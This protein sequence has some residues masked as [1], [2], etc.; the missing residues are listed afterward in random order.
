MK[1]Q[2]VQGESKT[3]KDEGVAWVPTSVPLLSMCRDMQGRIHTLDREFQKVKSLVKGTTEQHEGY[4]HLLELGMESLEIG[5]FVADQAGNIQMVNIVAERTMGIPR[6]DMIHRNLG[7]VWKEIGFPCPPF[8]RFRHQGRVFQ[9]REFPLDHSARWAHGTVRLLQDLTSADHQNGYHERQDRLAAM[10][11]MVGR[12][13][14]EIRNP[15]GSIEL[16]ASLI[17]NAE[18][19]EDERQ[20]LVQHISTSVKTLD[21]LLSNLLVVTGPARPRMQMAQVAGLINE[22]VTM[23]MQ[24]IREKSMDVQ[25]TVCPG[26]EEIHVDPTLVRQALLNILLNGIY[27]SEQHQSIRIRCEKKMN[28][29][30]PASNNPEGKGDSMEPHIVLSVQ[31]KGVGIPPQDQSRIFD[32]FFSRREGGTGLGLVMVHQVMKAHKGWVTMESQP[33]NGTTMMLCF[34]QRRSTA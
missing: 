11:E 17:G 19:S 34:P 15:L 10:G 16:F 14:H 6:Q 29:E 32:P 21:Q 25:M 3:L 12:I 13:A 9:G 7:Q 5:T 22:V 31:D 26:A 8:S 4:C 30:F 33:G 20:T 27:A 24:A 2:G 1:V 18:Q 23:A 28:N